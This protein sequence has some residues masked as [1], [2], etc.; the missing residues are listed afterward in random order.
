MFLNCFLI[1]DICLI[2]SKE[3][4]KTIKVSEKKKMTKGQDAQYAKSQK[5]YVQREKSK[6]R[7]FHFHVNFCV[8]LWKSFSFAPQP[9]IYLCFHFSSQKELPK[10]Q[11]QSHNSLIPWFL[12]P[13]NKA[14]EDLAL[15]SPPPAQLV[16]STPRSFC[17]LSV[18]CS[19]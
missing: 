19:G 15:V 6:T 1:E 12:L 2:N 7:N 14:T 16:S 18:P 11:T 5:R 17:S 8:L 4:E 13:L 3:P 9:P 10:T